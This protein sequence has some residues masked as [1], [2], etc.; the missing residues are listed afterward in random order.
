MGIAL[1]RGNVRAR[2][3]SAT[4]AVGPGTDSG[5]QEAHDPGRAE[6]VPLENSGPIFTRL[7]DMVVPPAMEAGPGR[8]PP[9]PRRFPRRR[10]SNR[11]H[12]ARLPPAAHPPGPRSSSFP[13]CASSS[14]SPR[15][16][17]TS[18]PPSPGTIYWANYPRVGFVAHGQ[19]PGGPAYDIRNVKLSFE[20][21]T[22]SGT[23]FVVTGRSRTSGKAPAAGSA[24]GRP[25]WE[26]Q[27][28]ARGK[29]GLRRECSR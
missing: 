2:T 10:R 4:E 11:N 23:L 1:A 15:P 28:G 14:C 21:K 8:I 22:A 18:E 27:P 16:R 19:R 6:P 13:C 24:S 5:R 20:K 9:L 12:G 17:S 26:G 7:E 25:S 3:A 29:N